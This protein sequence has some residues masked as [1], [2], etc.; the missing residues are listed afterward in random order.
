MPRTRPS[1]A[2]PGAPSIP[3][4]GR[5]RP[6]GRLP[7]GTRRPIPLTSYD[8]ALDVV[9]LA[10]SD[11]PQAE[12]L[13]LL[14]DD[15]HA[16]TTCFAVTGTE[17]P[18][19]VLDVARL[20]AELAEGQPS[21]HAAFLASVRPASRPGLLAGEGR[22][23]L[24]RWLELLDLFDAVAV[25]LLDWVVVAGGRAASVR[26]RTGMPSLWRGDG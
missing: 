22:G 7:Y 19:D 8:D 15:G 17:A 13:V 16:G 4:G 23:D 24:D 2:S 6:S 14:L 11:P 5:A 3:P 20:V 26:T 1:A 10:A 21:V 18:D 12:T 9:L 25:E